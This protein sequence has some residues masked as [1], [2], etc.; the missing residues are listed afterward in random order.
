MDGHRHTDWLLGK[1]QS[2]AL[3]QVQHGLIE[4]PCHHVD[5][6]PQI[7]ENLPGVF[8]GIVKGDQ[9]EF[10]GGAILLQL[11][12]HLH[13]HLGGRHGRGANADYIFRLLHGVAGAGDRILAILDDVCCVLIKGLAGLGQLQAA[14]RADKQ[15]QLQVFLQQIDLLNHRR[16]RYKQPLRRLVEAARLRHAEK[17][18]QLRIVQKTHPPFLC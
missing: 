3:S 11:R 4:Y 10:C 5:M 13:Q 12:P 14:V 15:L 1:L 6:L 2:I 17:R 8:Q 18:V 7:A 16:G 9:L